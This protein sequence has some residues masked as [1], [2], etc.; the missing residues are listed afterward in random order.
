MGA[1][2]VLMASAL[3]LPK[4]VSGIV[5]DCGYTS[6]KDIIFFRPARS[7]RSGSAGLRS[8]APR[9]KALLRL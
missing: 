8:R 6:P 9:R 3:P 5:A 4:S 1:S 2:T 7:S